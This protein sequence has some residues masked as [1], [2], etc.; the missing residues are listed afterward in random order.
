MARRHASYTAGV[1]V[2]ELEPGLIIR[3]KGQGLEVLDVVVERER[4]RTLLVEDCLTR[5]TTHV[6]LLRGDT[7][8]LA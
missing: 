6:K 4:S 3:R 1:S 5:V 2:D 7:V 8:S